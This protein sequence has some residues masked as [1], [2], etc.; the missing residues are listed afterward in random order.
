MPNL[1]QS[2]SSTGIGHAGDVF[3]GAFGVTMLS[4]IIAFIAVVCL[5]G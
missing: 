5:I 2:L 4:G 3:L 1:N